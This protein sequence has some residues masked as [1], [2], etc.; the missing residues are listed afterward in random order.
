M[1]VLGGKLSNKRKASIEEL[2]QKTVMSLQEKTIEI[3]SKVC[4]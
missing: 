2:P 4:V 1:K 3:T